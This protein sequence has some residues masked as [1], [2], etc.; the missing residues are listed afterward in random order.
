MWPATAKSRI[1]RALQMS[2]LVGA[3]V[4]FCAAAPVHATGSVSTNNS[5]IAVPAALQ[6]AFVQAN[7]GVISERLA[8]DGTITASEIDD[9][10][11]EYDARSFETEQ[12]RVSMLKKLGDESASI[13]YSNGIKEVANRYYS[14]FNQQRQ[15]ADGLALMAEL[16]DTH[17]ERL[18]P[19]DLEHIQILKAL[20]YID[21]NDGESALELLQSVYEQT[22][23]ET[24][25]ALVY[26]NKAR[27]YADRGLLSVA[28]EY[29]FKAIEYYSKTGDQQNLFHLNVNLGQYYGMLNDTESSK[30]FFY[31]A[32]EYA[33][34]LQ[35]APLLA[36][37]Y[38]NLGTVHN[39]SKEYDRARDYYAKSLHI[40]DSLGNVLLKARNYLN[41]GNTYMNEADYEQA[42]VYHSRAEALSEQ[43]GIA[44]GVV[45][46]RLNMGIAY[47]HQSQ[48]GQ[49]LALLLGVRNDLEQM[50]MVYESKNLEKQLSVTYEQMGAFA[51]AL[52]HHKNYVE[53]Y[54]VLF[55]E[56]S[57]RNINQLRT[58]YEVELKDKTIAL[59]EATNERQAAMLRLYAVL[60]ILVGV[61]FGS[62]LLLLA[63][64]NKKMK[65]LYERSQEL[66]ESYPGRVTLPNSLSEMEPLQTGSQQENSLKEIHNKI[67]NLLKKESVYLEPDLSLKDLAVRLATNERYVSNAISEYSKTSFTGLV[68]FYRILAARTLLD[69]YQDSITVN[70]LLEKCGYRSATTFYNSF[71]KFVGMTPRQYVAQAKAR[72]R[73]A[74]G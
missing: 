71:R 32:Y 34:V 25:A 10:F 37:S 73:V 31:R 57:Q 70:E 43:H 18:D 7:G 48:P 11:G 33:H 22:R 42:L 59:N 54:K 30:T 2:L 24:T 66:L 51:P 67:I 23:S 4:L 12:E 1:D 6:M 35:S 74:L 38:V 53:M 19:S 40:A 45:L 72:K 64:R 56:E 15:F 60:I 65:Q 3:L 5:Y 41:I 26:A 14:F 44:R 36:N 17:S 61:V 8:Y 58:R 69:K 68:N 46:S 16:L 63:Y 29:T 21:I 49:A 9:M 62:G 52:E 55:D 28:V 47:R 20:L 39:Q 13:G 27:I 50:G